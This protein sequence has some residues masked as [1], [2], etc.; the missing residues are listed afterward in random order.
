MCEG[1]AAGSQFVQRFYFRG[2]VVFQ[3][4][5]FIT[6]R[7]IVVSLEGIWKNRLH[8]FVLG[9][10]FSMCAAALAVEQYVQSDMEEVE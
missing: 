8:A 10:V 7:L 5:I 9:C 3:C 2:L 4:T 6:E 1:K